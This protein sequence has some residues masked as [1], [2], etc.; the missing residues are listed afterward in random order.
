LITYGGRSPQVAPDAFIASTA[1][2]I[3]D[4]E[5]APGASVWYGVVIRADREKIT[6]GPNSNV[7]DNSVLHSDPGIPVVLGNGVTVGHRAIVHGSIVGDDVLVGMGS[8]LLNRSVIGA[9][10]LIAA[11]AVVRE[12]D[13]IP[14]RSMVTGVP[15]KVIREVDDALRTRV[16]RNAV[17]YVELGAEYRAQF[18]D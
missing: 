9:G 14:E 15:G 8:V 1:V 11:G 17:N 18:R 6:I 5:V 16:L 10:S 12:G 4:V 7:Q 3:G 13:Q 2:L